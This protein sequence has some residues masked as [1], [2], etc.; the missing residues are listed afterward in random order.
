LTPHRFFDLRGVLRV[1]HGSNF[2]YANNSHLHL[3][4][5]RSLISHS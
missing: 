5:L 1:A 3:Q 2:F 4:W